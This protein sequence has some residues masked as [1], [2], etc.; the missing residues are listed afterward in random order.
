MAGKRHVA[1]AQS[2]YWGQ[3]FSPRGEKNRFVLPADFRQTVKDAS[4]GQRMLCL[5]KHHKHP[6]LVAFGESRAES[7]A[8]QIAHEERIAIERG[9]PFDID[10]RLA[11]VAGFARVSF[12]ESGR[13]V[14]PEYLGEQIE[15][16]DGL[17]FHGGVHQITIWA[18]AVLFTMGS[19]WDSVKSACRAKMAEHAAKAARK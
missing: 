5:D 18:P 9:Q 4:R 19:G 12:D 6:C 13:F 1:G 8:E 15:V 16:S 7:F 3:G 10:E 2:Q 11:Q 17:Y 14:M